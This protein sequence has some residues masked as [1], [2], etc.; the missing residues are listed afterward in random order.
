M[1][2]QHYHIIL[3]IINHIHSNFSSCS[4]FYV[5]QFISFSY[6]HIFIISSSLHKSESKAALLRRGFR[7]VFQHRHLLHGHLD[8]SAV[9]R[10]EDLSSA[11]PQT[12]LGPSRGDF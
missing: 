8:R 2:T 10:S 6:Y 3:C 7:H 12:R 5:H 4:F 1:Y 9:Q 11:R